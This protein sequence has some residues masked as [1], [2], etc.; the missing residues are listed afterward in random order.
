MIPF[1]FE[2]YRPDTLQEAVELYQDLSFSGLAPLYYGG[3]TEIISMARLNG[4]HTGAVIDLKAI[5]ECNTFEV[6]DNQLTIGA[7]VTLTRIMESNLFP[8]LG[9]AGGRVAD[10]TVRDKVT[11]GGNLCGKIIYREAALPLL[12]AESEVTIAGPGGARRAGIGEVFNQT[13]QLSPGELAVQFITDNSYT[14]LPHRGIKKTSL[15]KIGYPLVT[16]AVLKKA[17]HYRVA[18]SGLCAFPFRSAPVEEVLNDRNLPLETRV[19]NI[20]GFL[21]APILSD[22]HGSPEYREFVFKNTLI[23][24]LR[25]LDE[26]S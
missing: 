19:R 18:V 23:K 24:M 15:D 9:K 16:I 13:L 8:L 5:P 12:L 17:D 2:Y 3:G 1:D 6:R 10:H 7:A 22:I 14:A 11:L 25:E 26:V 4:L 20:P 21:P